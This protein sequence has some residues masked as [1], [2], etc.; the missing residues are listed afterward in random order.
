M[1]FRNITNHTLK[2]VNRDFIYNH[3]EGLKKINPE[4][5]YKSVNV[6]NDMFIPL[7]MY[8]SI[9]NS[10]NVNLCFPVVY[11]IKKDLYGCDPLLNAK[12]NLILHVY[13]KGEKSNSQTLIGYFKQNIIIK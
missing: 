4:L 6:Y 5:K 2:Y 8:Y 7:N 10:N 9:V 12:N 11:E 1:S 3:F 13:E